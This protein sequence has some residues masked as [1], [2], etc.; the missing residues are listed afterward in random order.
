VNDDNE[1]FGENDI[2]KALNMA[3]AMGLG[4]AEMEAATRKAAARLRHEFDT[5]KMQLDAAQ[6]S[7]FGMVERMDDETLD[8]FMKLLAEENAAS[9]HQAVG[10]MLAEQHRRNMTKVYAEVSPEP[11]PGED[12]GQNVV[13]S[14]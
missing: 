6:A 13:A 8:M 10:V 2:Q 9:R 14:S 7:F 11:E 1:M 3:E 12:S 5:R 4:G